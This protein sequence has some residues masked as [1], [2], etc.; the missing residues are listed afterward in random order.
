M[1]NVLLI[2]LKVLNQ[3]HTVDYTLMQYTLV[4]SY[5]LLWPTILVT[6]SRT[7]D[8]FLPTS[9]YKIRHKQ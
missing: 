8:P 4:L 1:S 3:H 2:N 7:S 6:Q 5:A 9:P